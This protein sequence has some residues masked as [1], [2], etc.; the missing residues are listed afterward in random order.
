MASPNEVVMIT[1]DGGMF[2][3]VFTCK[4]NPHTGKVIGY[5]QWDPRLQS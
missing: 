1:D 2:G 5:V 3:G 4:V